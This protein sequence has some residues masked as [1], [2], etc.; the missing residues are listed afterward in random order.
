M[1]RH[2]EYQDLVAHDWHLLNVSYCHQCV[3][4]ND[5]DGR[6][7]TS[8]FPLEKN[9]VTVGFVKNMEKVGLFYRTFNGLYPRK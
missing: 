9:V 5:R 1:I 3:Q 2:N 4:N 6:I 7:S 8:L